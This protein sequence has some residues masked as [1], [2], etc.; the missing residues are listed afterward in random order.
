MDSDKIIQEL[1]Q[2]FTAPLPEFYKRRVVFWYDEDGEFRDRLDEVALTDAK[3]VALTGTNNFAVKKLLSVD[4]TTSNYL[5]YCPLSYEKP[6]DNWLLDIELYSEEFRADLVS[7]WMDELGIPS[8]PAMRKQVKEYRKYF[9]A[10]NRRDKI[11][12]QSKAP[13]FPAQLHM[14]VMGAISGLKDV[15]PAAIMK[16][17]LKAG[18]D[19]N[20]NYLYRE[21]VN[22]GADKAFWRMVKQGSGY[23]SDQQ[24]IAMLA[25][26]MLLTATTRTMRMEY[27]AGL[28]GFISSPHQAFCFDFVSDWMH[29]EDHELL[30]EIAKI[31]EEELKLP[32]RFM[33]LEVCDL[34]DTEIF[35]CLD[36]VILIKLMTEISDHII[37]VDVIKATVEKRRTTVGYAQFKDYYEGILQVANMQAF[38]KEHTTGFH[39]AEAKKVWKEYTSE[40]YVMD[41]Y[42][43]LFHKSFGES[44]KSYNSDL[45]DLFTHVMEKVEG[46]Y[47]NWFLG[48][49]GGNWSSVCSEELQ[50]YGR[51]LEIPQQTDFYKSRIANAD[52]RVFV[53]ISDALRYEVA[54]SLAEQLR[55]ETQ[56]DVKLQDVQG[57]F[58]TITKFGMA[59]LLPHKELEVE[60]HGEVLKVM[61]DGAV[62]DAGCRDKVLKTT[63]AKSVAIQYRDLIGASRADRSALVK[64][65]D[66][67][68]IYHNTIDD[69]SHISDSMVFP[70]C[71]DAIQELKN[72][73]KIICNDFGGTHILFTADHGFLYTYSPLTEDDKISKSGF[74]NNIVEYGRRFA[75]MLK[76]S[77]P[78]FLQKIN[79]LCGGTEYDGFAPRENVRIKMSGSGLNF[80]HGGISLQEMVVP[81]IDYHFLRNDSSAYKRNKSKYDTKPVE[82]SLLS[83]THK[84]SNMIFSLSFYQREPV[85][86][87]REAATYNLYFTDSN[88]KQVSDIAKIIADKTSD[89]GQD[90]T[91]RCS[92]NLK[93]LKYDS[94][95]IYYLVIADSDGLVVSREEF[96]IDIAF[97]ADEFGFFS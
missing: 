51:I 22:Y 39:S 23:D 12:S 44:L 1:N 47:T 86:D 29:S 7:I 2:R 11:A 15:T 84:V 87:N 57:I 37:D 83:A 69:A 72:L 65:M 77:N 54:A 68:Y 53:V 76:D 40:Y 49:L 96:Q 28:D 75:I 41:T 30:T 20:T 61:A 4:D 46:L 36:E 93:S 33:K 35:P 38:Y 59:A 17:V 89:N 34:V 66:V 63:N 5:V 56:A 16:E 95:E 31:V 58:P 10:K 73:T 50:K 48:Q 91:F 52:S 26:H 80:V 8:T 82:V 9:N 81:V 14:A 18:L 45:H 19:I 25:T 70:A 71:D 74:A 3:L 64:G 24:D 67:V 79:L 42:Y 27:L 92:F 78:D 62:T 97:A 21:F 90:R 60:L 43:R 88:G 32:T 55:R 6:E 85:G 13:T 94:K